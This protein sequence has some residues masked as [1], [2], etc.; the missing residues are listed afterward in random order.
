MFTHAHYDHI[1][2]LPMLAM[3]CY[4]N[5]GIVH[6]YGSQAV[7][8][9]LAEHILNGQIYSRFFETACAGFPYD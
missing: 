3:N 5:E 2:D 7:R 4:L 6:A 8:D 9:A 1:R